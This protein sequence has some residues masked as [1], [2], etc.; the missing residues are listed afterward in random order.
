MIDR[1]P[2][3]FPS[4]RSRRR[5]AGLVL[6]LST[7][8]IAAAPAALAA[9]PGATRPVQLRLPADI[10]Y[11]HVVGADSAV[12]FRHSTHVEYEG[13]RCTGCHPKRFRI[14]A[15]TRRASHREMNAGG[16][17]G[18]CHD[19]KHAF[20]V[21]DTGSCASCHAGSTRNV[22]APG[23]SARARPPAAF[24]GPPPIA[25]RR[26]ESSPGQVTFRHATHAGP[27]V[28]CAA[29]HPSPFAMKSQGTRPDGAMHEGSACGMCHDGRRSFGVEDEKSCGRCHV[30]GKGRP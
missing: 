30:E 14:L 7:V 23:D 15:A 22:G 4:R 25:Y 6:W 11:D 10:V 12:V 1:V 29:C 27:R 20:D 2:V 5:I 8:G 19:G 28:P 21:R 17:C 9:A 16:S 26:G 13:D 18:A 24:R 3:T